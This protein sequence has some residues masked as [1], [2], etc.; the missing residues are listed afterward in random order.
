MTGSPDGKPVR[1]MR[2]ELTGHWYAVTRWQEQGGGTFLALHRHPITPDG[3]IE[4][5]QMRGAHDWLR[6]LL[7]GTG[8]TRAEL[9]AKFDLTIEKKP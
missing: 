5:E 6:A 8:L 2:S 4:L 1:I 7:E 3:E 9:A